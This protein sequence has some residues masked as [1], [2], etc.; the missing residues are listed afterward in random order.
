MTVKDLERLYDYSYWANR[1]LVQVVSQLP[2]QQFTQAA[3]GL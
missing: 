2:P 1:K 3:T